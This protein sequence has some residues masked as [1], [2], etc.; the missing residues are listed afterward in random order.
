VLAIEGLWNSFSQDVSNIDTKDFHQLLMKFSGLDPNRQN[1]VQEF[2]NKFL[3]K[4]NDDYNRVVE[5][6]VF[7]FPESELDALS[8]HDKAV[9]SWNMQELTTSSIV[10]GT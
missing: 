8:P 4:L 2:L 7:H 9:L 6:P 10:S 1:D 3:D 5:K